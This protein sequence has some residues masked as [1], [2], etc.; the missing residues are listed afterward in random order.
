MSFIDTIKK[1]MYGAMKS[2]EKD[3]AGTLRRLLAKLKDKQINQGKDLSD[4]D[5]LSVIKTLVKQRKESVDMYSNAGRMELAEQEQTELEILETYLPKMLSE[6]ETRAI[7][8]SAIEDSGATGLGD[9]GKVMPLVMQQGSGSID[10][11]LANT[12]LR[13]LLV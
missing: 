3:K 10:G 7:V 8:K 5:G 2:G 11:K 9:I 4:Q 1:D 6:D 12:I 13:E